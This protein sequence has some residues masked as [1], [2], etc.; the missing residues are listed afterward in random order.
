MSRLRL[1]RNAPLT[2][3]DF[4]DAGDVFGDQGGAPAQLSP[5]VAFGQAVGALASAQPLH[6]L[7]RRDRLPPRLER[8]VRGVYV[9]TTPTGQGAAYHLS[10]F[11][12][13]DESAGP[14][15]N[16]LARGLRNAL[17]PRR[18]LPASEYALHKAPLYL[19]DHGS[20]EMVRFDA[21]PAATPNGDGEHF[22]LSL[23]LATRGG[24]PFIGP[25]RSKGER[26][27]IARF[28]SP[29]GSRRYVM[30]DRGE[31]VAAAQF[32]EIKPGV[33]KL[34]QVFVVAGLRRRGLARALVARAMQ[35]FRAVLPA[36]EEDRSPAG[37]AMSRAVFG[38][39]GRRYRKTL[40]RAADDDT[41]SDCASFATSL[42]T[43]RLY[44]DNAG[45]GG[46]RLWKTTVVV[47]DAKVL[48]LSSLDDEHAIDAL[49]EATGHQPPG[50]TSP[51]QLVPRW[52][53]DLRE[54]GYEWVLVNETYPAGTVTWV[55]VGDD[56][57]ELVELAV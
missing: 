16:T 38:R 8:A 40:Y 44:L 33:L 10:W 51:D 12:D 34:A 27:G 52:S 28:D 37:D 18:E 47:D 29:H 25:E 43:A 3:F 11:V 39:N 23:I 57:P 24:V 31:P 6:V 32:M 22:D 41:W 9:A 56:D 50:A 14:P 15:S 4:F 26:D 21:A 2:G 49:R 46:S 53:Y 20:G 17:I 36:D 35:D 48:D 1:R 7:L 45:F 54:A 13:L 5:S 42:E 30:L 55:Y 19:L